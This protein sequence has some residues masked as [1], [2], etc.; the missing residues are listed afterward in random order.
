MKH[1]IEQKYVGDSAWDKPLLQ[2]NDRLLADPILM[3]QNEYKALLQD[4][5]QEVTHQTFH[6][7]GGT[8]P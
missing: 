6:C 4:L 2:P 1:S 7:A 3:S 8:P 5:V